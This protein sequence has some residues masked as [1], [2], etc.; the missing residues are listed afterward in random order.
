AAGTGGA[1]AGLAMAWILARL[2]EALLPEPFRQASLNPI[3]LDIR[4]LAVSAA[5]GLVVT[6]LAVAAP[7]WLATRAHGRAANPLSEREGTASRAG[8]GVT[9]VLLI[10]EVAVACA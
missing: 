2:A 1:G 4:A 9:R 5:M 7:V 8:R 10:T 6:F 3:D